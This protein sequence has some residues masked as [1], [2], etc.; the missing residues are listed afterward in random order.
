M[1]PAHDD[2]AGDESFD[3]A[4]DGA[5]DGAVDGAGT[6]P[7]LL[8]NSQDHA[9]GTGADDRA[10]AVWRLEP[11][12]RDLDANI[13]ALPPGGT[14]ERHTGP[15]LDVLLHV[16]SGGGVLLSGEE[17]IELAPGAVVWLPR[18]TERQFRA[19]ESGLRY[20]SVHARR[21]DALSIT[22]RPAAPLG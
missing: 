21:H 12:E 1:S 17:S 9:V 14:I 11:P 4:V 16:L 18:H 3:A 19:H 13:I 5:A 8:T 6:G 2:G 20:L 7:H 10:G 15:A 22:T